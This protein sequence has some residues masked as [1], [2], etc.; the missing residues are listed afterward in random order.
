MYNMSTKAAAEIIQDVEKLLQSG[1]KV[2]EEDLLALVP[3]G[4]SDDAVGKEGSFGTNG[5]HKYIFKSSDSK[6]ICVK[7]HLPDIK[8][9]VKGGYGCNSYRFC[10]FQI[11]I[12]H[13]LIAWNTA[14]KVV[15]LQ[16]TASNETHI[17]ME[18]FGNKRLSA[19]RCKKSLQTNFTEGYIFLLLNLINKNTLA[20][21]L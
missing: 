14:S 11:T 8:A 21:V 4:T 6:R 20:T 19:T 1:R 5:I 15:S 10:T 18:P 3:V 2:R 17:P 13:K 12:G 16:R 7:W 9:V